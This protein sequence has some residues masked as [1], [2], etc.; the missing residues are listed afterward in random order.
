LNDETI[1]ASGIY[2]ETN[3][4]NLAAMLGYKWCQFKSAAL[5][6][7]YV[8]DQGHNGYARVRPDNP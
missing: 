6:F 5:V 4:Q 8:D 2:S 3:Q 7:P 1:N